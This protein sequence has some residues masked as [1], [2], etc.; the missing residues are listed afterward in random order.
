MPNVGV[1]YVSFNK[2]D[3]GFIV[4]WTEAKEKADPIASPGDGHCCV[5]DVSDKQMFFKTLK[6]ACD[7][8]MSLEE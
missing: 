8:V 1:D 7:F 4:R 5:Q 6:E 2:I 3:N